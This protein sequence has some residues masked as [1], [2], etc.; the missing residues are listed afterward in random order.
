MG[1]TAVICEYNPF[2]RGHEKQ[3]A[4]LKKRG[5]AVIALMSGS[6]V[7]RGDAAVFPKYLR[8]EAALLCGADLVLEL[9]YPWCCSG[10]E[11]FAFGAVS[12]I[13]SLNAADTLLF[14]SESGDIEGL[15]KTADRLMSEEYENELSRLIKT[16]RGTSSVISLKQR[17]FEALYGSGYPEQPNDILAIE[18][19]KAIKRLALPIK[20][21]TYKREGDGFSAT[22]SRRALLLNDNEQLSRLIPEKALELYKK[23]G[24]CDRLERAEAAILFTIREADGDTDFAGA[25]GG[26]FELIKKAAY[27]S[28]SLFELIKK[29]TGKSHTAAAV[30]R[31]II[32]AVLK[33]DRKKPKQRPEFTIVLAANNIGRGLLAKMR[34]SAE[35]EILTKPSYKN[36][37]SEPAKSQFEDNLKAERLALLARKNPEPPES[38]LK[39]GPVIPE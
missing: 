3:L 37:L 33:T 13:G 15:L 11:Q 39:A 26:L 24:E 2:H 22:E 35:I 18:Y 29:C 38:L 34:K 30:R 9:P 20:A 10:A 23:Y 14:G 36:R 8:A 25:G 27:S 1:T 21:E 19:I 16:D 12:L 17:A 28:A 6:L 5:D 31:A 7:Q 32:S 4:M